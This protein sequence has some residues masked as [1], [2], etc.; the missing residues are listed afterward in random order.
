MR[1]RASLLVAVSVVVAAATASAQNQPAPATEL[2]RMCI[3]STSPK[4]RPARPT[5]LGKALVV[6]DKSRARCRTTSSCFATRKATTGTMSSFGT[7]AR[8]RR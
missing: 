8:K 7:L 2:E 3:T 4:P 6:P 5:A 1:L